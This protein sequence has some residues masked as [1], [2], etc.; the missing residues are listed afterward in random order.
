MADRPTKEKHASGAALGGVV[1]DGVVL[2][3]PR[4]LPHAGYL[5]P[6]AREGEVYDLEEGWDGGTRDGD[7]T[8]RILE[9]PV[10]VASDAFFYFARIEIPLVCVLLPG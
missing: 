6:V 4:Q 5:L 8:L 7:G 3:P 1:V 2:M 9:L 10:V